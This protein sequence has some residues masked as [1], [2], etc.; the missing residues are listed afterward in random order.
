MTYM[1][2][3]L[4][5]GVIAG[6]IVVLVVLVAIKLTNWIFE[7]SR[8][9]LP[10]AQARDQ[11][12]SDYDKV[13]DKFGK[14]DYNVS[15]WKRGM[16]SELGQFISKKDFDSMNSVEQFAILLHNKDLYLGG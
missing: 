14:S 10:A 3:Q 12:V 15:Q 16:R 11:Q 6:G 4:F 2:Y 13:L 1:Q 5:T 7:S 9:D 8:S